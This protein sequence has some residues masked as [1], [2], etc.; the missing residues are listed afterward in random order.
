MN[1]AILIGFT[2]VVVIVLLNFFI[3]RKIGTKF[4]D[5]MKQKDQRI[6]LTT[7]ILQGIKQIKYLH[8]ED[9]FNKKI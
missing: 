4:G 1:N 7:D 3:A 6:S 2:V 5:Y 8:W 9:T